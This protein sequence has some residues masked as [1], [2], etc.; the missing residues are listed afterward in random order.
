MNE[1]RDIYFTDNYCKIYEENGDGVL[2]TFHIKTRYGNLIYKFL[3]R[4]IKT[5]NNITYYDITTPY[6]YGGP[7]IVSCKN[8]DKEKIIEIFKVKFNEYCRENNIVSEFIRFHPIEKNYEGMELY[9]DI[10]YIRDT[11]YIQ[12]DD[13]EKIWSNMV[14]E[15]RTA[16][17]KAIKNNVKIE[18]TRDLCEFRLLYEQTMKKNN[19][20]KYYFFSDKFL[21]NTMN[22]LD[23]NIV[24]FN[25]VY[26]EK[27]I[28]SVMAIK[29]GDY[30]H[31]HLSGSDIEYSKYRPVNL[32]IYEMCLW[33][34]REGAK[35][36]HL[37]GGYTGNDDSLFKFKKTFS[38]DGR[39]KFFIGK[40]IHNKE[41][42]ELLVELK[43]EE[44]NG[45]INEIYFPKYRG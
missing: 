31:Y 28:S 21:E 35:Y 16:T 1:L 11:V 4:K 44:N 15:C 30:V 25:A 17:R 29:Y 34:Y 12:I 19:A 6:G 45:K 33:G 18:Q 24:I 10:E 36:L 7:I 41:I 23:D 8:G 20:S 38:K 5:I 22:F 9:M 13:E 14:S 2:E 37:G 39:A 43:R 3:K 42:Y 27:V 40:K 26:E 32:L